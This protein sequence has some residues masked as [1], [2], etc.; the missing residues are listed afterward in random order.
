MKTIL[1]PTDFSENANHAMQFA[2]Q[3]AKDFDARLHLLNTYQIPYAYSVPNVN[4]L[5]EALKRNA[6]DD[7]ANCVNNIKSNPEHKSLNIT[8]E[9]IS[10]DL[11]NVVDDIETA[12]DVDLIVLG[13]KG[14]SGIKEVLIGSNAQQVVYHSKSSVLVI[15]EQASA[16]SFNNIALASDL[17]LVEEKKFN[18]F[19]SLCKKYHAKI[20]VVS[21]ESANTI[22]ENESINKQQ[23]VEILSGIDHQ[24]HMIKNDDIT[25]GINSFVE[26]NHSNIL[27]LISKK[28]SFFENIFHK[29][30]TNK[31]ACHTKIPIFVMKEK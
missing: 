10:G 8:H 26:E 29:S 13:T 4:N 16:F 1:F 14:A 22:T 28:Y 12:L 17:T 18:T 19:V 23:L 5:L 6:I 15:P 27:A 20:T 11:I 24:F 30:I 2:L 7:L 31:L 9:A 3:L 25:N 21:V